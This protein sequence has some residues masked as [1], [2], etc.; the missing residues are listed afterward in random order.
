METGSNSE[1]LFRGEPRSVR[2]CISKR[3]GSIAAKV[4]PFVPKGEHN[5]RELRSWAKR[6]GFVSDYSGEAGTSASE[7]FESSER[8]G[9]GGGSSPK[10]EIDPVLGRTRLNRG[11]EIEPASHGGG[12]AAR[13]ENEPVV[14]LAPDGERKVGFRGNENGNANGHGISAVAPV[15]EEQKEEED[16]AQGD[17]KVNLY[18]EGEEPNGGG[19]HGPSG[20]KCRLKENPGFG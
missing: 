7:K 12:G 5:P 14:A 15:P 17:V 19:W 10:I 4:E 16:L 20:L 6:T 8:R 18:P 1:S 2:G 9:V 13:K 11:I 3:N